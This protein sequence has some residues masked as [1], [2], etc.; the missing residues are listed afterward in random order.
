MLSQ[1]TRIRFVCSARSCP[2][3]GP[4]THSPGGRPPAHPAYAHSVPRRLVH[5]ASSPDLQA[6]PLNHRTCNYWYLISWTILY[7]A[8]FH[9]HIRLHF[10][11]AST[12]LQYVM[13]VPYQYIEPCLQWDPHPFL[14]RSPARYDIS[15]H[16]YFLIDLLWIPCQTL[17]ISTSRLASLQ[18]PLHGL[19]VRR[20]IRG[21]SVDSINL[22]QIQCGSA[23]RGWGTHDHSRCIRCR[24][25]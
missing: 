13:L 20:C 5:S 11:F 9:L 18:L 16:A 7:L 12:S 24:R 19:L 21:S 25:G 2:Y 22:H 15:V 23:A 3:M 1:T 17:L 14:F 6:Y 4:L 8:R 10:Y